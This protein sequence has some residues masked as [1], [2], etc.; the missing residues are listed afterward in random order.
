MRIVHFVAF[1]GNGLTQ[2]TSLLVI[3]QQKV[4]KQ[5]GNNHIQPLLTKCMF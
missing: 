1:L 4:I 3:A 5:K 2:N